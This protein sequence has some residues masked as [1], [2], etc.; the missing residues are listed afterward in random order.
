VK[1]PDQA[2][3]FNI[4]F[5]LLPE[6]PGRFTYSLLARS[7]FA[8]WVLFRFF[9]FKLGR[10][11]SP[12]PI[13][14]SSKNPGWVGRELC[15]FPRLTLRLRLLIFLGRPMGALCDFRFRPESPLLMLVCHG[16]MHTNVYFVF[17]FMRR[18]SLAA[19]LGLVLSCLYDYFSFLF[20]VGAPSFA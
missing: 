1:G 6:V 20:P 18:S 15:P 5:I 4:C 12:P 3:N 8:N 13:K 9:R 16:D 11:V 7:G 14:F 2:I 10:R 19:L 17:F